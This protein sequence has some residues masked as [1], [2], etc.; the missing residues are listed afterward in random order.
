LCPL[1]AV[2]NS[3]LLQGGGLLSSNYFRINTPS[4]PCQGQLYQIGAEPDEFVC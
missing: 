2:Q 4:S 1:V 3:S